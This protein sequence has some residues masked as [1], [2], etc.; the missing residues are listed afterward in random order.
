MQMFHR[1]GE[2]RTREWLCHMARPG[3]GAQIFFWLLVM[4]SVARNI[5]VRSLQVIFLK[6]FPARVIVCGAFQMLIE[7][8]S[9][10]ISR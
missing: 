9:S 5:S 7:G 2:N 1:K 3:D 4:N 6:L 10:E 8:V